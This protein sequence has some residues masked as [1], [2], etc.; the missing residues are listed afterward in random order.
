[1]SGLSQQQRANVFHGKFTSEYTFLNH[2][3]LEECKNA[4]GGPAALIELLTCVGLGR[5][6]TKQLSTL[7]FIILSGVDFRPLT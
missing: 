4:A 5:L 7:I 3:F 2:L 6:L 1:M